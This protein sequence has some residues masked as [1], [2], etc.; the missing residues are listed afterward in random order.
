MTTAT[1]HEEDRTWA[2]AEVDRIV[3]AFKIRPLTVWCLLTTP[4]PEA[5]R[6]ALDEIRKDLSVAIRYAQRPA[7][8]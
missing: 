7:A 5:E 1:M 3:A 8:A 6:H 4:T 2:R